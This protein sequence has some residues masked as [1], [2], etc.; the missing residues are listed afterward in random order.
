MAIKFSGINIHSKN[1]EQAFE[2]YKG[3]GFGVKTEVE[4]GNQW[5]GAEFNLGRGSVLWIWRD[6]GGDEAEDTSRMTIQMVVSCEDIDGTYE[7]LKGKG[8]A[9]TAPELMFYGGKEMNLTD[10]DG[11]K[12]LFLD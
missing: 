9:V 7:E 11:N 5:Y 1:P 2:F 12:I 6:N 3:L 8:Y 10:P 4:A